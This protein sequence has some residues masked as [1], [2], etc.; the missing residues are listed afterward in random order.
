M[1]QSY[2]PRFFLPNISVEELREYRRKWLEE[3]FIGL[4]TLM[5]MHGPYTMGEQFTLA[6]IF[7]VPIYCKALKLGM[8]Q[9][10]FPPLTNLLKSVR[11]N[12]EA[13]ISCPTDLKEIICASIS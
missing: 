1:Q 3:S 4:L 6:D 8:N 7:V 2:V 13:W 5:D 12:E 11:K 10:L 9:N